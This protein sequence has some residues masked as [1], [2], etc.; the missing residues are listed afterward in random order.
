MNTWNEWDLVLPH[1]GHVKIVFLSYHRL[2]FYTDTVPQ[3]IVLEQPRGIALQ[4]SFSHTSSSV[5]R[6]AETLH[7]NSSDDSDR[8]RFKPKFSFFF[9]SDRTRADGMRARARVHARRPCDCAG[10]ACSCVLK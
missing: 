10:L 6:C 7:A 2:E 1:V 9:L 3:P 5:P 4:S 8:S